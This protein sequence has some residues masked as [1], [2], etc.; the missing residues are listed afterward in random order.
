MGTSPRQ[1]Q[2]IDFDGERVYDADNILEPFLYYKRKN[3]QLP[4]H[5]IV[6]GGGV[7]G[8]EY[9]SMFNALP[10]VRVTLVDSKPKLLDF[11]DRELIHTLYYSMR[12][13][14]ATF[15]L[16]EEVLL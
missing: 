9:A 3:W 5:L 14:G 12:Q 16:G 13:Q 15:R 2:G 8:I 10:G 11:V 6:L 7:I 1:P 4:R